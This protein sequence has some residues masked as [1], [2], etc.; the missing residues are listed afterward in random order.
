[1]IDE[2]TEVGGEPYL[3]YNERRWGGDGWVSDMKREGRP[4]GAV[5]KR[6]GHGASPED[7]K[8]S[9]W[10]N[11]LNAHCLL[12]L[13]KKDHGWE[14]KHKLEQRLFTEYYENNE[15]ISKEQVLATIWAAVFP[16]TDAIEH[17]LQWLKSKAAVETVRKENRHANARGIS[18]VP[19]FDI[20]FSKGSGAPVQKIDDLG[21]TFDGAQAH[22]TWVSLFQQ[23]KDHLRKYSYYPAGLC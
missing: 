18:S 19:H 21:D 3:A 17:A 16:G 15:N 5:F 9:V 23:I 10:A 7:L 22:S 1:M 14:G 12:Q 4:D 13:A 11:T 20:S 8:N 6:W 2:A